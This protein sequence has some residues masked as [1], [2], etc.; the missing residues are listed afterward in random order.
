M[1]L[2]LVDLDCRLAD[3]KFCLDVLIV[4]LT[5]L[6]G[7]TIYESWLIVLGICSADL[8]EWIEDLGYYCIADLGMR[9]P[10]IGSWC[11]N[12]FVYIVDQSVS[13]ADLYIRLGNQFLKISILNRW[14]AD[15]FILLSD[16][17]WGLSDIGTCLADLCF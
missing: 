7:L 5:V 13:L 1:G 2:Q 6:W 4:W 12:W 17:D 10:D 9:L 16:I 14:A 11:L 3:H 8:E 15:N